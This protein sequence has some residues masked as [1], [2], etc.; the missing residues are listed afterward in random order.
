MGRLYTMSAKELIR[1]E[2]IQKVHEKRLR[3]S[4]AAQLLSLSLRQIKRLYKAFLSSGPE[5]LMNKKRELPSNNQTPS[6]LKNNIIKLVTHE[7]YDFGPTLA[8]EKLFEINGIHISKETLRKIMIEAGIW[9]PRAKRL[10]RAYQPRY[11]RDCYGE[12][13]QIDGSEHA[14]F[15]ER[16]PKCTLL[17]YI[18]DATSQLMELRFVNEES[19]FSYFEATKNYLKRH[20]K[21]VAF[22]SDKLSVFRINAK[23][24]KDGDKM[25]QFAR[26]LSELNID[27]ICANTCQ[28][29]GRVERA[30]KTL[31]DRLVK[32]LRLRDISN[33]QEGNRFLPDF[34]TMHN[35][36]FGKEPLNSRNAHRPLPSDEA[37]DDIFCWHED[38]TVSHN[39]T[40]QYNKILYLI[41]DNVENRKL[42]RKKVTIF[43]YPDGSIK[44]KY[45][46]QDIPYNILHDR[47][48]TV[49]PG[50]IVENKRLGNV[51]AFIQTK[52]A[53]LNC[54]RSK[55]VPKRYLNN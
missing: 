6:I 22:Y 49:D 48:Q 24:P 25:T 26:A 41:V 20:G 45:E 46:G 34:V 5:G 30:N 35:A 2:I 28:A 38:R 3:Q 18:D 10:K 40:F 37:L 27:I 8:A 50:Q 11:R 33:M 39:L 9:I 17:V 12:L 51:L 7:Y 42:A 43:D 16:G 1:L 36:K 4:E 19:T 14:W 44:I 32:E 31:Q 47:L 13:I 55:A 54:E 52:Q 53:E 29:K 15:E 21:P 23:N